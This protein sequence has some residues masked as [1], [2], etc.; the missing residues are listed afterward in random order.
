MEESECLHCV[1]KWKSAA[2]C[3]FH[4]VL[5]IY[6]CGLVLVINLL[7]SDMYNTVFMRPKLVWNLLLMS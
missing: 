5:F 7:P 6:C 2:I 1:L 4:T 3:Y